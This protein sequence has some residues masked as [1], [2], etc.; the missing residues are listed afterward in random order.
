LLAARA[1][2]GGAGALPAC[3][4]ALF[5]GATGA[6]AAAAAVR[7]AR[8]SGAVG[9]ADALSLGVAGT[10]ARTVH[11]L[12]AAD[13]AKRG[14]IGEATTG[15]PRPLVAAAI[16]AALGRADADAIRALVAELLAIRAISPPSATDLGGV[17]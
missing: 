1:T 13:A 11:A 6:A 15:V 5:P 2:G 12:C 17:P 14:R 16:R 8:P 9:L 3:L 4:V 7:A 10:G